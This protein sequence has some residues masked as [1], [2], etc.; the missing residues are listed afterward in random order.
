VSETSPVV[1]H[2]LS[3][4]A[5]T[6]GFSC[7]E[8]K[9]EADLENMRALLEQADLGRA[10]A[11]AEAALPIGW[12]L[13]ELSMVVSEDYLSD[14]WRALAAIKSERSDLIDAWAVGEGDTPTAA[15]RDLADKLR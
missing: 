3:G 1:R 10:W 8:C 9:T 12:T 5:H 7:E 6:E 15:L 13:V 14:R 11:E 4:S 2:S